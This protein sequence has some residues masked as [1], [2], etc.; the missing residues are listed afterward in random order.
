MRK[1]YEEVLKSYFHKK[2]FQ[3]RDEL[4]ISQ[5]KWRI[6]WQWAAALMWIWITARAAAA[7]SHWPG[8]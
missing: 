2:L 7:V 1:Q 4:G 8:F 5:E 6:S 3:R